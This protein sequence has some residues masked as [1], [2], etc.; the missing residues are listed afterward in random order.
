MQFIKNQKK[1]IDAWCMYD[2]A[3]SVFNLT[4]TSAVFPI[5]FTK[6]AVGTDGSDVVNFLGFQFR[7]TVLYSYSISAA[8]L[9]LLV[10]NPFLTSMADYS[11]RKKMFMKIFCYIGAISCAYFFFFTKDTITSIVFA[12]MFAYIGWYG[13]GIF[14]NSFLPEIVTEE[15]YDRVSSRGFSFGYIGSVI[16][17][18]VNLLMIMKPTWFGFSA[19]ALESGLPARIS[20]LTVGIWW[21]AFAQIPFR[22]LPNDAPRKMEKQW[23]RS[24]LKGL[25]KVFKEVQKSQYIKRFFLAFFVYNMGVMTVIYVATLFGTKELKLEDSQL[26]ITILLIQLVGILGAFLATKLS[27]KFGNTKALRIEIFVWA[28]ITVAAY[29]TKTATHFYILAACVGMVMGGIQALSRSTFAKLMPE[30]TTD[31]A[32]YF[33]L[34]DITD[35]LATML[36]TLGFGFIESITGSMRDSILFLLVLFVI[37]FFLLF[38]IPSKNVY[39]T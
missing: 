29:F 19:E 10:M 4:I 26:I 16:L 17:L 27:K 14:Y 23:F 30:N 9:L 2:W 6:V 36:G 12:F 21:A 13:S 34:Y 18:I 22:V 39:R 3:N 31:T 28:C 32:S 11:G 8:M 38:R 7:N 1:V 15:H 25:Q 37:S 33:G 24:S 20:F 5:Y 35:K